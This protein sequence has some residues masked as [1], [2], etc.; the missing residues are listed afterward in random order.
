MS[1]GEQREKVLERLYEEMSRKS[2]F[3]YDEDLAKV[4]TALESARVAEKEFELKDTLALT[5][6]ANADMDRELRFR[7]LI[8]NT[9]VTAGQALLWG[10]IFVAELKATR[11]FE[12]TGTETSA[13]SR[14]LKN[15]FPK[16]RLF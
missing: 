12:Q 5:D 13:A 7:E 4:I 2:N 16:V 8:V 11:R 3:S 6:N 10:L 14:W 1:V 15:S 9:C